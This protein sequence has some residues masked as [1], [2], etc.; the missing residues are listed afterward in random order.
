[1]AQISEVEATSQKLM[2]KEGAQLQLSCPFMSSYID[3]EK[4]GERQT[5]I[6]TT[7]IGALVNI[8]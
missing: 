7:A 1:M 2:A 6:A 8:L 3:P 5:R 4:R